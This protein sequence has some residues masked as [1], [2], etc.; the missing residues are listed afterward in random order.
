MKTKTNQKT[1]TICTVYSLQKKE[2]KKKTPHML[3]HTRLAQRLWY[4]LTTVEHYEVVKEM[5]MISAN[6]YGEIFT[7]SVTFKKA[8]YKVVY[9][10][11]YL[12]KR[13]KI[14]LHLN[15]SWFFSKNAV[16]INH[17]TYWSKASREGK[18]LIILSMLLYIILF[19]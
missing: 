12:K 8:K 11:C 3:P 16:R 14:R 10:V 6:G 9:T 15:Q 13:K 5:R 18:G 7:H 2:K 17:D 1:P 4:T 19:L